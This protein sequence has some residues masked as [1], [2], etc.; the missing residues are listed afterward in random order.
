VEQKIQEADSSASE[1]LKTLQDV[2]DDDDWPTNSSFRADV[3]KRAKELA[4][5]FKAI[6]QAL[7]AISKRSKQKPSRGDL[8]A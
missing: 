7:T 8:P 1:L 4:Y 3:G 2:L 5:K 6:A